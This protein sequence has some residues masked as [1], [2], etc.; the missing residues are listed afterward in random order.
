MV[1]NGTG[2]CQITIITS[3]ENVRNLTMSNFWTN[4][5]EFPIKILDS[6]MISVLEFNKSN[7]NNVDIFTL[8]DTMYRIILPAGKHVTIDTF[9]EWIQ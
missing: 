7:A 1:N 8:T 5:N 2:N 4:A 6:K 9:L 3:F